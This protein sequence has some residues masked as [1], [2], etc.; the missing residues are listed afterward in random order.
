MRVQYELTDEFMNQEFVNTGERPNRFQTLTVDPKQATPQQRQALVDMGI[1]PLSVLIFLGEPYVTGVN[2]ANRVLK[3]DHYLTEAEAW[4]L[5]E[6]MVEPYRAAKAEAEAKERL[7]KEQRQRE[8]EERRIQDEQRQREA[9]AKHAATDARL[10]NIQWREDGTAIHDLYDALVWVSDVE[11]DDRFSGNWVKTIT[12]LDT[13]KR[14]GY[15]YVGE[16][17]ERG[18]VELRRGEQQVFLVAGTEGSRKYQ[19]TTY[20]VVVIN[21]AGEFEKTGIRTDDDQPGWALRIRD[22]IAK[23]L[24]G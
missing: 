22:D 13:S 20:Q 9:E 1:R 17:V 10:R 5:I 3:A 4:A 2:V 24:E 7:F 21:E 23:L 19:T 14:D 16:W 12:G 11:Q 8:A 18:T 15:M 6:G